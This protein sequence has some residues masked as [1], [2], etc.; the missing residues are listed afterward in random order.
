LLEEAFADLGRRSAQV[1]P[2]QRIHTPL[3]RFDEPRWG[4]LNVI[5]G[6]VPCH[7]VAAVRLDCAHATFPTKGGQKRMEYPGDVSGFVLVWD[8]RTNELLGIVHDH[9]VSPLRVGGTSGVVAK[10]CVRDDAETIGIIGSGKQAAKQVEAMLT[11][12]PSIKSLRIYSTTFE[13]RKSFADHLGKQFGVNATAVDSA[14]QAVRGV[15]VAIAATN[16]ADPVL[17][18]RWIAEG[19][20]VIGMIG[21]DKFDARR[22]LDDEFARRASFV[23]ANSIEQITLDDQPEIMS[24]I[25]NGYLSWSNI[26]EVSDLCVG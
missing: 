4:W 16:S 8:I 1:I 9:A 12:R 2:R 22:E 7:G 13:H 17:F 21:T 11:V 18:G 23:I 14:E 15:D 24:P 3:Q 19:C 5:P 25:R 20:H 26:Y 6:V 10:Y